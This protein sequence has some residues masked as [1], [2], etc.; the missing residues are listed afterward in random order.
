MPTLLI[1]T[2][3]AHKVE[4]IRAKLRGLGAQDIELL[5]LGAYAAYT[6]PEENGLTFA[7]NARIKAVA[8]AA[9]S[10][11]IA[12]ADDSGLM[13]EALGGAPGVHSAR[14]AGQGHDDAAN[15]AKLLAEL[16]GTPLKRRQA[17]FHCSIA[18]AH[19]QGELLTAEGRVEGYILEQPRGRGGFGYDPL[20]YVTELNRGMAELNMEEKN[21]VSHRA[22]ALE[23]ALPLLLRL[24]NYKN[25]V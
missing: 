22:R 21:R 11:H 10:G 15:N 23:A 1:A 18:I 19:P 4:E 16:A 3:N 14:Y 6:P 5:D 8:A 13:V 12:L 25:M 7:A 24:L 17:A 9:M 20:F 2:A